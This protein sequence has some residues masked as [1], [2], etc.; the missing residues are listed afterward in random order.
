MGLSNTLQ[1][2]LYDTYNTEGN[3]NPY[4]KNYYIFKLVGFMTFWYQ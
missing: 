1:I 2:K 3:S 4:G